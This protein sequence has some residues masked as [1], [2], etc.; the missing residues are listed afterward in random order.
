M[1]IYIVH[2]HEVYKINRK[3]EKRKKQ[4]IQPEQAYDP[5]H[6]LEN[7]STISQAKLMTSLSPT[8]CHAIGYIIFIMES[9]VRYARNV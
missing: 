7:R 4:N 9:Y 5:T 8:Q 2:V 6:I 1:F 3:K